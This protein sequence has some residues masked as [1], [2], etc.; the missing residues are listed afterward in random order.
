MTS[1]KHVEQWLSTMERY[2]FPRI[3]NRL[4]SDIKHADIL[5][6]ALRPV[7]PSRT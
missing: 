5:A 6:V 1:E 2:V 4:V 3:G 7:R